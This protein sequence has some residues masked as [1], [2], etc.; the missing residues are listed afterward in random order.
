MVQ[1]ILS[2]LPSSR[3]LLFVTAIQGK[4]IP[5][6]PEAILSYWK[7]HRSNQLCWKG[8]Y[9]L[10]W[11]AGNEGSQIPIIF[12]HIYIH[13]VYINVYIYMTYIYIYVY[14]NISVYSIL[15]PYIWICLSHLRIPAAMVDF[16]GKCCFFF[17][18]TFFPNLWWCRGKKAK[19]MDYVPLSRTVKLK[20]K[21]T[22][23]SIGTPLN[24][25]FPNFHGIC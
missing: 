12:T 23:P 20:G 25:E 18:R 8:I 19:L 16:R 22:R 17:N 5:F 6:Q 24:F 11:L 3:C 2:V 4:A 7:S 21:P 15:F 13:I 9:R 1:Q 10:V 14:L